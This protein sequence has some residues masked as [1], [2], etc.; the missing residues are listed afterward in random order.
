MNGGAGHAAQRRGRTSRGSTKGWKLI[1]RRYK[2][3]TVTSH[4]CFTAAEVAHNQDLCLHRSSALWRCVCQQTAVWL[5]Q[6]FLVI[7]RPNGSFSSYL[8]C[9]EG[10]VSLLSLLTGLFFFLFLFFL[11]LFDGWRFCCFAVNLHPEVTLCCLQRA[12][13]WSA[14]TLPA[15]EQKQ[16][17]ESRCVNRRLSPPP[18]QKKKGWKNSFEVYGVVLSNSWVNLLCARRVAI[19]KTPSHRSIRS[20]IC[21]EFHL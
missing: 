13:G 3:S 6:Q 7:A 11:N 20:L 18:F 15:A 21:S 17:S 16:A 14:R 5:T 2:Q 1:H 4:Q 9:A 10:S 19:Q 8:H 12:C